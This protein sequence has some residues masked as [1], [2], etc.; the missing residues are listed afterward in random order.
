MTNDKNYFDTLETKFSTL[1]QNSNGQID[2]I[3][4]SFSQYSEVVT[5]L[6][7]CKNEY[8]AMI[9]KYNSSSSVT[10][11]I[12]QTMFSNSMSAGIDYDKLNSDKDRFESLRKQIYDLESDLRLCENSLLQ[13][14]S[15]L[16]NMLT[17]TIELG[18]DFSAHQNEILSKEEVWGAAKS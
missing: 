6:I 15:S 11:P 12:P 1:L 8:I 9:K 17:N 4:E 7:K 18:V 13:D 14:F 2:L 10:L 3:K 16:K 5:A